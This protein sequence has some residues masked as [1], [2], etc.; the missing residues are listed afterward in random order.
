MLGGDP[1]D[2]SSGRVGQRLS[3]RYRIDRELGRGGAAEVFAAYDEQEQRTVALKCLLTHESERTAER[4]AELF[5]HEFQV[6]SQVTHANVIAAYDFGFV[7]GLPYYTMELVD[8]VPLS[9]AAPLPAPAVLSLLRSLCEA[10]S[11]V[12]SRSWVHRDLSPR[13]VICMANGQV[14]LIDF[15]ATVSMGEHHVP[16]GTPPCMPPEVLHQEPLDATADVFGLGALAYYALTGRYAYPARTLAALPSV[17]AVQ[18]KRPSEL[19]SD[20][21]ETLDELIIA[22]LSTERSGRPRSMAEVLHRLEGGSRASLPPSVGTARAYLDTPKLIGRDAQVAQLRVLLRGAYAGRGTVCVVRGEAGTGRSRMLDTAALEARVAGFTVVRV[23]GRHPGIDV[24]AAVRALGASVAAAIARR[25]EHEHSAAGVPLWLGSPESFNHAAPQRL[26]QA[27]SEL[28]E[29]LSAS[30]GDTPLLLLVDDFDFA[31][32]AS[33]RC[34]A[35]LGMLARKLRL[36]LVVSA[37]AHSLSPAGPLRILLEQGAAM[38][39][40]TLS[41]PQVE[42]WVRSVFGDV[43]NVARLSHWLFPVSGGKPAACLE[44]AHYLVEHAIV[45]LSGG[46]WRLPDHFEGLSL[47]T[48]MRAALHARLSALDGS[49]RHFLELLATEVKPLPLK[50]SVYLNAFE[51]NFTARNEALSQ[52]TVA[53]AMTATENGYALGDPTILE[54]AREQLDP[55]RKR[56]LHRDLA[57]RHQTLSRDDDR[58]SLIY[59]CYHLWKADDLPAADA[60]LG[61]SSALYRATT[62][63]SAQF[64]RSDDGIALYEVL[65]RHRRDVGRS[66][67]AIQQLLQTLLALAQATKPEL[68]VYADECIERLIY[69]LGLDQWDTVSAELSDQDRAVQCLQAASARHDAT[70]EEQRGLPVLEALRRLASTVAILTGV[71][72]VRYEPAPLHRLVIIIK[73]VSFLSPALAL[74]ADMADAA[75]MGLGPGAYVAEQQRKILQI[76]SQPIAQ[77]DDPTREGIHFIYS[78]YFGM[79]LANEG[80]DEA[81]TLAPVLEA[82]PLYAALG[83]QV[84]RQHALMTGNYR[85]AQH[86]RRQRE[87]LALQSEA[88]DHHLHMSLLHEVMG[89]FACAD[90]LELARAASAVKR[91][92]QR[93]PGWQPWVT[94]ATVFSHMLARE[95]ERAL[96]KANEGLAALAPFSHG[97]F[98]YLAGAK[99][100]VLVE[101]GAFEEAEVVAS[102]VLQGARARK[103]HVDKAYRFNALLA[104]CAVARGEKERGLS[105]LQTTLDTQAV[106]PGRASI[107]YG[108]LCETGCEIALRLEDHEL[109]LRHY[110]PMAEL[111]SQHPGLRAVAE[112][113]RRMARERFKRASVAANEGGAAPDVDWHTR[114][115]TSIGTQSHEERASY[116]LSLLLEQTESECGQLYRIDSSGRPMLVASRPTPADP[117]LLVYAAKCCG[118][119]TTDV[120]QSL[121]SDA[122]VTLDSGGQRYELLWLTQNDDPD[123]THGL[124]LIGASLT[125][126][127]AI[128]PA[129]RQAVT[130][131]LQQL[132]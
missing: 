26:A 54:W 8:G 7:D 72:A 41:E 9:E 35:Q 122:E 90:V 101:M 11:I 56:A 17:W 27:Q 102:E 57:Q 74:V 38:Q 113:W 63:S 84:R 96:E 60:L 129:L 121:S 50:L 70:P 30:C 12:H 44:L 99:A 68:V 3:G 1:K 85:N 87:L 21:P 112:R 46:S 75:V 125:A 73:R 10:L 100:R 88:S 110:K 82:S 98:H 18:P 127:A 64:S 97:A 52:L 2:P 89:A 104:I 81:L 4:Q 45:V 78:Y 19:V 22:M 67:A 28:V 49:A 76:S 69:D 14:K 117:S 37:D 40:S 58:S 107:V 47:P 43:P 24:F 5:R 36:L 34:I 53:Q 119:R 124:V 59:A 39:L 6:L 83:L 71:Y 62:G 86:C 105:L 25:E 77:I 80:D 55:E 79:R 66:P 109:F 108:H 131:Q 92:A 29:W 120:T 48:S 20:V 123:Q 31:D 106:T 95:H 93:F 42:Q 126:L 61:D 128:T 32:P 130:Q 33:Q 103:I 13:N 15:G 111:F 16:V 132:A 118:N 65:L 94:L 114:I 23:G 51:T 115:A 116:L 91:K